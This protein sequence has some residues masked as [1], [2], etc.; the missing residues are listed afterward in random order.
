LG[1]K[2]LASGRS[3]FG[4]ASL[5]RGRTSD[6]VLVGSPASVDGAGG[7]EEVTITTGETRLIENSQDIAGTL[8]DPETG[9]WIGVVK[10]GDE[11]D[12]E[13][14]DPLTD[15][16]VKATRK[17]FPSQSVGLEGWNRDFSRLL[18]FTS[19]PRDSG[20]FWTVAIAK[21]SAA[22]FGYA[23]PTVQE[24]DVGPIRMV[25]WKA[26]DGLALHG[27][28]SL[29]P[30]REA[31]NLPVIVMPH[32]GPEARDYPTFD[33]WAQAFVSQGYAVFQPNFRGSDGYGVKF[34]NAGFGEF[35]K[36]M[37]SDI[38]DGLAELAREGVVDPRR[39]CIIGGSYG[40]YAALAG[41]TL[42]RGVYRCAVAVAGVS[43]LVSFERYVHDAEGDE[44]GPGARYWRSFVGPNADQ[45]SPIR[46]A[47]RADAPILLIHGKDDTVVPIDQSQ[48]MEAALKAAGKRVELVVMPSEDHWLSREATRELMLKSAVTFV[49]KYNPSDE[50]PPGKVA[51]P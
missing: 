17:A 4:G 2:V 14:F 24:A 45:V 11:P 23:Y 18:V 28:L 19:G 38:S 30:G 21:G 26:S 46:F 22:P 40:G 37:Q 8:H 50:E 42:Q 9:L 49:E 6:T 35:G 44:P 48:R 34:R 20:T 51:S 12:V 16:K 15:A 13:M 47:S 7:Y 41:V 36:K 1:G 31:R 3:S 5:N 29:P 25:D 32:G 43:D 33:W 27:V 39:A 10:E